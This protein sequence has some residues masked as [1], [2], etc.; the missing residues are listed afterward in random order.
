MACSNTL[1]VELGFIER[2]ENG[3][4]LFASKTGGKPVWLDPLNL[5][6]VEDLTCKKC[7]NPRVILLQ[8]YAPIDHLT[9]CYHRVLYIFCCKNPVC[10]S[11][12]NRDTFLILR[13]NLPPVNPF[14]ECETDGTLKNKKQLELHNTV[15][16][17]Q[18]SD[19]EQDNV[20][21]TSCS[22]IKDGVTNSCSTIPKGLDTDM[23]LQQEGDKTWKRSHDNVPPLCVVC[24][25][26]GPKKCSRCHLI[27][28]CSREHQVIHWKSGHKRCCGEETS[29]S[30]VGTSFQQTLF[31]EF[32]IVTEPEPLI[33]SS[34]EKSE[35]E[36]MK[37]YHQFMEQQPGKSDA[38]N[39]DQTSMDDVEKGMKKDKQF[40]TFR[41]RVSV[42]PDQVNSI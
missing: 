41:K 3:L 33:Q 28:Y 14:Y 22:D 4:P 17:V 10:H 20:F 30:V 8:L 42:E 1:E 24:G 35:S 19:H 6:C 23:S 21:K 36:R 40:M 16:S 27:N 26:S 29:A 18:V 25:C 31:E 2:I 11:H 32:E 34:S 5:P 39:V 37:A 7:G 15:D 13:C 38:F 9:N 12:N